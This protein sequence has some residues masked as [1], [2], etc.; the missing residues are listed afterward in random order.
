MGTNSLKSEINKTLLSLQSSKNGLI[1]AT[2]RPELQPVDQREL[3][4]I[5]T[6]QYKL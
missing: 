6:D 2:M 3:M 1:N 5:A 4:V